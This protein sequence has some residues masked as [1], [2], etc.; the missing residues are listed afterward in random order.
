[1][2]SFFNTPRGGASVKLHREKKS[3]RTAAEELAPSPATFSRL[4]P[5]ELL[6]GV[7]CF[8]RVCR[9]MGTPAHEF[10]PPAPSTGPV[11]GTVAQVARVLGKMISSMF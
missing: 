3:Q 4:E 1:M 6:A 11:P 7:E 5:G 2:S 9:W 8:L 10:F